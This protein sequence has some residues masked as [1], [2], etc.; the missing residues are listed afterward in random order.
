[1]GGVLNPSLQKQAQLFFCCGCLATEDLVGLRY[2]R[3]YIEN[4]EKGISLGVGRAV[5]EGLGK[6]CSSS[7]AL[8]TRK[9]F[10]VSK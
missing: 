10:R 7:H 4:K 5:I 8:M 6:V 3:E 2:A 9:A 1:M